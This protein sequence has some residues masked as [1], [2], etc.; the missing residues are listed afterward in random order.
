MKKFRI[1]FL[2]VALEF[3]AG[4]C[5]AGTF[6][7]MGYGAANQG[8]GNST[9]SLPMDANSQVYNPALMSFQ[10]TQLFSIGAQGATTSFA[11]INKVVTNTP[12]LGASSVISSNVDTSTPDTLLFD[13]AYQSALYKGEHPLHI[14]F[15]VV[16]PFQRILESETPN[17]FQPQYTM[18]STDTQRFSPSLNLSM[19]LTDEFAVGVG[20]NVYVVQ[21]TSSHQTLVANQNSNSVYSTDVRTGVSPAAGIAWA[22]T[23]HLR[24]AI[25]YRGKQDYQSE[26]DEDA[27]ISLV[28]PNDLLFSN[29]SS[30]DYDPDMFMAG[31]S[32]S[33]ESGN[34]YSGEVKYEAWG[35]YNGAAV[36]MN[37]S[38]A[39]APTFSQTLPSTPFHDI[40]TLHLGYQHQFTHDVFRLGYAYVPTPVPDPNTNQGSNI[41]DSIKHEVFIGWGHR[42]EHFF[43]DG[44]LEL[45]LVGFLD[46][47]VPI[48][49]VKI[50]SQSI[51]Y[52]GY[53]IGGTIFG[54]GL[55]L[56]REY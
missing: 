54:Y 24:T 1:F 19:A 55:T 2:L 11:G 7:F 9:V 27:T 50:N 34:T 10:P 48:N 49:V 29:L 5:F 42:W 17:D 13:I 38:G 20:A 36:Q 43:L 40:Y 47:L 18:Y 14:G 41:L 56:T 8:M 26:V 53:T 21:G 32:V 3:F 52:P 45:D 16:A 6:N 23:T 31:L 37:F 44:I 28:G 15:A 51:G 25:S 22:P 4:A 30:L 46:Y 35:G 39:Y 12:N 33:D